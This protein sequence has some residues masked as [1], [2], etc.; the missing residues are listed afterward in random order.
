VTKY[1]SARNGFLPERTA[2]VDELLQLEG[3]VGS[4]RWG[5]AML[6]YR[7]GL[8]QDEIGRIFG[9]QRQVVNYRIRRALEIAAERRKRVRPRKSCRKQKAQPAPVPDGADVDIRD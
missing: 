7:A 4:Q 1:Q 2:V 5:M 8:S 9:V 3:F 6:Y